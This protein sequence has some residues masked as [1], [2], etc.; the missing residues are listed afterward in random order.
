[1]T[2]RLTRSNETLKEPNRYFLR[3]NRPA[4]L[5]RYSL[6]HTQLLLDP[7][8]GTVRRSLYWKRSFWKTEEPSSSLGGRLLK[9]MRNSWI[10]PMP[11]GSAVRFPYVGI[12][13]FVRL[14]IEVALSGQIGTYNVFYPDFTSFS[15]LAAAV[16]R[17]VGRPVL[18]V[19]LPIGAIYPIYRVVES[20]LSKF[21]ARLPVNAESLISLRDN[22][23]VANEGTSTILS[24]STAT[25]QEIV[26]SVMQELDREGTGNAHT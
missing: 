7:K 25:L 17:T 22:Q 20:L 23:L 21:G 14:V 2:F 9:T 5:I 8:R 6:A 10:F 18:T 19:P 11:G 3:R 26:S 12:N 4:Y 1:M 24:R 16:K 13:D 15:M